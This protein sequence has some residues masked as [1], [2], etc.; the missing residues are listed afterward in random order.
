VDRLGDQA[1]ARPVLARDE[2]VRVGR[3][4]AGDELKDRPHRGRLRDQRRALLAAQELVLLLEPPVGADGAPS[5]I[6]LRTI[7]RSRRFSQGLAMKSRAPRRMASTA[8]STL[9]Q[10]VM[11]TTGSVGSIDWS[12]LR[13]S[14]PSLPLVVSRA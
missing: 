7:A 11:M 1:L 8:S 2:D 5:S 4:H 12:R 13:R 9:A 3:A 10:A 14:R 6:W